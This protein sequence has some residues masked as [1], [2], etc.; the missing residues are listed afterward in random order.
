M[1][2]LS[3][4]DLPDADDRFVIEECIGTGICGKVFSAVDKGSNDRRVAIKTQ[5]VNRESMGYI[6]EEHRVLMAHSEHPNMPDFYGAYRKVGESEDEVWFIL[7]LCEGGSAIDLVNGLLYK[8]RRMG[9]EHIAYILKE[10]IKAIMHLHENRVMHRDIKA[11]NILLTKDGD[12]KL[13]DFGLSRHLSS[14]LGKSDSCIG[15]PCWMAPEVVISN[16][17]DNESG[18]GNRADIWAIGITAIEL[19]EGLAPFENM[20]PTRAM[21]QIVRNPPPTLYRPASWSESFNDFINECL[22]KNPEH[23]PFIMELLEHPFLGEVPENN[24]HLSQEIKSLIQDY[25]R[26][27]KQHSKYEDTLVNTNFYKRSRDDRMEKMYVED[28]AALDKL[29]EETIIQELQ[30]RMKQLQY[31]TFVG[32][33]LLVLNPNENHDIYGEEYHK[34]YVFKSRSNNPPHIYAVADS[35]YQDALHHYVPQNIVLCGETGSGKT[36]TCLHL[37]DHLLYMGKNENINNER[38]SK[39][40]KLIH[41]LTHAS[42]PMNDYS[43]RC[44]LKTEITYGKTGKVSGAIFNVV[45]LEKWRVSSVEMNQSNYNMLYYLYDGLNKENKLNEYN[46]SPG[47]KHRYLRIPK[48]SPMKNRPRDDPE[49]NAKQ[50]KEFVETLNM[51]QFTDEQIESIFKSLASI[52]ILGDVRFKEL[53]INMAEIE[54]EDMVQKAAKLLDIDE[55]KLS[56]A[57]TNYCL[58]K[59]G[60]AVRRKHNCDEARDA[61]DVLANTIY[62]RLVDYIVNY[63]NYKLS[64]GR[65]IFGHEYTVKL[66]DFFGFE[67]YRENHLPQLLI[68]TFNEQLHYHFLQRIFAWEALEMTEEEVPFTPLHYYDNKNTLDQILGKPEGVI[69]L[70]DDASKMGHGGEYVID[71]LNNADHEK[72]KVLSQ[73]EF[74]ISHFTG[75]VSYN[76]KEMADR[77][78]DFLPPEIIES[79]RLSKDCIIK[80]FF[81]N[82]LTKT[83][84]LFTSFDENS[85]TNKSKPKCSSSSEDENKGAAHQYSQIKKMRTSASTFRSLCLDILKELSVGGGAGG[86]HFV[87]CIRSDLEGQPGGFHTEIIKQQLRAM[88]VLDTARARQKGYPHRISFSEFLR[89]YKFLAFDFDE[90]VEICKDNCRLLLVRLKME[91]WLI[92]KTKVFLKYYNEEY[93]ARLYETQVKKI[94]KIQS[95][96]RGFL[97]K[98]RM[99]KRLAGDQKKQYHQSTEGEMD[100]E[101][102]ALVLQ[103]AYRGVASRKGYNTLVESQYEK[104]DADTCNFIRFFCMKWKAKSIFQVLLQYRAATHHELFNLSQQIHLFNQ[105]LVYNLQKFNNNIGRDLIDSHAQP[106]TW[107]G[108]RKPAILKLP[109]RLNDIPYFDTSY[110]CDPLTNPWNTIEK[111]EDW[112]APFRWRETVSSQ[113]TLSL[114]KEEQENKICK[115]YSAHCKPHPTLHNPYIEYISNIPYN[116]D[117]N[118]PIKRLSAIGTDPDFSNCPINIMNPNYSEH[119]T[120]QPPPPP[121]MNS[122]I[123][124]NNSPYKNGDNENYMHSRKQT[125]DSPKKYSHQHERRDSHSGY[126]K[127]KNH[128]DYEQSNNKYDFRDKEYNSPKNHRNKARDFKDFQEKES[129]NQPHGYNSNKEQEYQKLDVRQSYSSQR[130]SLKKVYDS[131]KSNN[132]Y[133]IP[134][135]GDNY[136]PKTKHSSKEYESPKYSYNKEKLDYSPRMGYPKPATKDND[137]IKSNSSYRSNNPGQVVN[138][139]TELKSLGKRDSISDDEP[140]FN[141]QGMLRKTKITRNSVKE[142]FE[143]IRSY[144][145]KKKNDYNNE[146][147]KSSRNSTL[148]KIKSMDH[149]NSEKLELAPGIFMEGV[150]ADL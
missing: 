35:A 24:Y 75:S 54:N 123:T 100:E 88:A 99:K 16:P 1:S 22:V 69:T 25:S 71:Y 77:N 40:M 82:K 112:D 86:T 29:S 64:Y 102:A 80:S 38:I 67:S 78:R 39:G 73:M 146:S 133:S 5:R 121:M 45:Q 136:S 106:S 138:P 113:I 41:A 6:Q 130:N 132:K 55:K 2:K 126:A 65:A 110:M 103:K 52:L 4:D 124:Y 111:E 139:I 26:C 150:V 50:L 115:P 85:V 125:F 18:Y 68:N 32:D 142:T 144:S 122:P 119:K 11:S 120:F 23:R 59:K 63:I 90:N 56:W 58:I 116:R 94:I 14:T 135:E 44:V 12:V 147:E 42:T 127:F 134:K 47:R 48:D 109:F 140:P 87:K 101:K 137:Y 96:L 149:L 97:A 81:V 105:H 51:F 28:L 43:T 74:S 31:H 95:M 8:N 118:V 49:R 33:I 19:A 46:L 62:T 7:E 83:G 128:M 34:K 61:R 145:L 36:T 60:S 129:Y 84:N 131:P 37:L 93:L 91:G 89:R 57:L 9:E 98:M 70:I 3:I 76:A 13:A 141:F 21:F 104:L 10:I 30:A 107:L 114:L 92:G 20:H 15:S 108:E 66:L 17:D 79:L 53:S 143:N 148:R 72:V 27:G 117:P